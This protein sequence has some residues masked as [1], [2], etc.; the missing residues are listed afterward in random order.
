MELFC[1]VYFV[2][3]KFFNIC[4]ISMY[5][6]FI[7]SQP[8]I[9]E[10]VARN[11][12]TLTGTHLCQSPF[13]NKVA[14]VRPATSLKKEALAEVFSCEFCETSKNIFFIKHFWTTASVYWINFQNIYTFTYQ[15]ALLR[16]L[17]CLFLKLSKAFSK[18]LNTYNSDHLLC[19]NQVSRIKQANFIAA[20]ETTSRSWS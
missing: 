5:S 4:F 12:T 2:R 7:S 17:F 18:S 6:A 1:N 10:G 13:F 9:K 15:K 20:P 14:G 8:S 19:Q 3:R 16:K 11:V